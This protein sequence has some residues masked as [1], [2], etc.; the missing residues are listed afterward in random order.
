[1]VLHDVNSVSGH[2]VE[3]HAEATV[4]P[5]DGLLMNVRRV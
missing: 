3:P 1:M 2:K 4:R 5:R